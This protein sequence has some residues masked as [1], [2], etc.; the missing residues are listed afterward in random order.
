MLSFYIDYQVNESFLDTAVEYGNVRRLARNTGYTFTGRPAAFG[1]A[2]F[3]V[4]IPANTSGLG[5]DRSLLPILKT[6]TEVRATTNTT[7][8]LTEDVDFNN[9]KNEVVASKFNSTTGKPSEYAIRAQGQ[10]KSTVL[11]RTTLDVGEF[12]R[13]RR[14]RVGP[15]SIAEVKSVIDSEGHHYYQ[16]DHLSQDVVYINRR[17]NHHNRY[18]R[19]FSNF[20]TNERQALYYRRCFRSNKIVGFKHSWSSPLE[21]NSYSLILSERFR[22]CQ[23][24]TR[25]FE[26]SIYHIYDISK[27]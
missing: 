27:Y 7:F 23:C 11:Y 13:F 8:V 24:R 4:S 3:Y 17:R 10:V 26:F 14:L 9:P 21:H 5:P 20:F 12:T 2:T 16:V 25:K 22:L 19:A 18:C 1:I 6:G 15:G